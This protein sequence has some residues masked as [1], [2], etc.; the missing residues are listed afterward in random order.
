MTGEERREGYG[1]RGGGGEDRGKV[2][3]EAEGKWMRGG[4]LRDGS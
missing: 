4:R 2:E 3:G 1:R